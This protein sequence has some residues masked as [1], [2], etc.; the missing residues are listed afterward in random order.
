MA[1]WEDMDVDGMRER[2]ALRLQ[3]LIGARENP[4]NLR[5]FHEKTGRPVP[6]LSSWR[7]PKHPNWPDMRSFLYIC[8]GSDTS[9]TWLLFGKG[10]ERLSEMR[11]SENI[12]IRAEEL[13][14]ISQALQRTPGKIPSV[15]KLAKEIQ[16]RVRVRKRDT[17]D[18]RRVA[19]AG[20][21]RT[22]KD[23]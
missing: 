6:K 11:N 8:Y 16:Q 17:A 3:Q 1:S 4:K 2:F 5:A 12:E 15:K 14:R 7:N 10:R 22:K 23:D 21:R 18:L 20:T 19:E 13:E 9:P